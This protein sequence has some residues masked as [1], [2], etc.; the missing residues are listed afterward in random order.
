MDVFEY[1]EASENE[2]LE[3]DTNVF[4]IGFDILKNA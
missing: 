4:C 3:L 2:E 1:A